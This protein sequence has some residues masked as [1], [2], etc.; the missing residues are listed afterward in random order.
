MPNQIPP[1]LT[2]NPSTAQFDRLTQ[3]IT[4][5]LP[6]FFVIRALTAVTSPAMNAARGK[7]K[8]FVSLGTEKGGILKDLGS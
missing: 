7:P 2:I 1:V 3:T 8:E 5:S 6:C 4:I